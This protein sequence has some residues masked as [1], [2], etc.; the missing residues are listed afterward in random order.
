MTE[1][2]DYNP[3]GLYKLNIQYYNTVVQVPFLLGKYSDLMQVSTQTDKSTYKVGDV[4]NME[5]LFTRVTQLGGTLTVTDPSKNII[6]HQFRVD[7]VHTILALND[8]TKDVGTY[9]YVVQMEASVNQV[10]LVLLQ[11]LRHYQT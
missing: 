1:L 11:I 5:L 8:V 2:A 7:S 3:P 4:V 9:S 10:R 6:T